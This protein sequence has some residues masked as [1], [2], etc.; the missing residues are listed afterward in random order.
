MSRFSVQDEH[1][2]E[3]IKQMSKKNY[4]IEKCCEC[5]VKN[6]IEHTTTRDFCAAADVNANTLYYYFSSKYNILIECVNYGFRQFENKLF[7]TLR[8][9]D[10]SS[11]DIFPEL[12]KIGFDYAPLMRF[13]HQAVS[14]PSYEEHREA[15]FGKVNAFYAGFGMALAQHFECPYEL[16]KDYIYEIMT[17]LSYFSLWG[18]RDMAAL[19]FNRIFSDFKNAVT[20]YKKISAITED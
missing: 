15:Q 20:N 4:I 17:L 16:V 19:Q 6:G 5:F 10:K 11:F 18:S 7:D 1:K 14:S 13:L 2:R 9:F 8:E 3:F 12:V